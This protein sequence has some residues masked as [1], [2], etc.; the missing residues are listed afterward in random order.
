MIDL[1]YCGGLFEKVEGVSEEVCVEGC[2][3]KCFAKVPI[4]EGCQFMK[5]EPEIDD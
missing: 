4:Y 2:P 5:Y 3:R 1:I